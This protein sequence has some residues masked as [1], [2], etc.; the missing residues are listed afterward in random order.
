MCKSNALFKVNTN[1]FYP[2]EMLQLC[3]QITSNL[4]KIKP[5]KDNILQTTWKQVKLNFS[6]MNSLWKFILSLNISF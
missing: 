6:S 4:W 5:I 3:L 2:K 1:L